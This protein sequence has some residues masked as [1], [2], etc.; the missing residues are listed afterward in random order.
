MKLFNNGLHGFAIALII[1]SASPLWA[2]TAP[3]PYETDCTMKTW[4]GYLAPYEQEITLKEVLPHSNGDILAYEFSPIVG[5]FAK[6]YMF[7]LDD[8]TCFREVISIGSYAI[9]AIMHD[10]SGRLFHADHY[11]EDEHGTLDF[12]TGKP[13]YEAAKA[14]ALGVLN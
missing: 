13:S 5:D 9:T 3:S 11:K 8:G 7:L 14:L 2:D 1:M 4:A 12:F 10:G 6:A